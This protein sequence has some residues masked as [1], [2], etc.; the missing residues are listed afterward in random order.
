MLLVD[1]VGVELH[2][3]VA[4]L[5][6][7]RTV[8]E[9]GGNGLAGDEV[10]DFGGGFPIAGDAQ[11]F[12]RGGVAFVGG[13]N[14]GAV[15]RVVES[16]TGVGIGVDCLVGRERGDGEVGLCKAAVGVGEAASVGVDGV[17]EGTGVG[18]E[19]AEEFERHAE[20][21]P[22]GDDHVAFVLRVDGAR[23]D[24]VV[25]N[26]MADGD[27][28][29]GLEVV[30]V[31]GLVNIAQVVGRREDLD[32]GDVGI[33]L[34]T[35]SD[36]GA[37]DVVEGTAEVTTAHGIDVVLGSECGTG[38]A[39]FFIRGTA[40]GGQRLDDVLDEAPCGDVGLDD[41]E[42]VS[43]P[44]EVV[45]GE[46]GIVTAQE[47][48]ELGVE[49]GAFAVPPGVVLGFAF[50][51][52]PSTPLGVGAGRQFGA[53]FLGEELEVFHAV[54]DG[55][56]VAADAPV[57]AGELRVVFDVG[58]DH[59]LHQ[60]LEV[61]PCGGMENVAAPLVEAV[62]LGERT[63]RINGL[64]F[65]GQRAGTAPLEARDVLDA[66]LARGVEEAAV[67]R[68]CIGHGR[69]G[70][71]G[72]GGADAAPV[73]A[74]V[75]GDGFVTLLRLAVVGECPLDD[76]GRDGV[77]T[78]EFCIADKVLGVA[79]GTALPVQRQ[80]AL[81]QA[82]GFADDG[83]VALWI[84]LVEADA[85]D[86]GTAVPHGIVGVGL[87]LVHEVEPEAVLGVGAAGAAGAGGFVVEGDDGVEPFPLAAQGP[88]VVDVVLADA[89]LPADVHVVLSGLEFN[90]HKAG[91]VL[92]I[93][94][95][96]EI[97]GAR[98]ELA[99]A[100]A[101]GKPAIT[102]LAGITAKDVGDV[103]IRIDAGSEARVV[104]IE[105]TAHVGMRILGRI[106]RAVDLVDEAQAS[107]GSVVNA[108][109]Q[110]REGLGVA[111]GEAQAGECVTVAV[112]ELA[113]RGLRTDG[114]IDAA[115]EVD[116]LGDFGGNGEDGLAV[117]DRHHGVGH[118]GEPGG[119]G[120]AADG[121][122]VGGF[123]CGGRRVED[124]LERHAALGF[125]QVKEFGW[126]GFGGTGGAEAYAQGV[127]LNVERTFDEAAA[128]ADEGDIATPDAQGDGVLCAV[129]N[130]IGG[131]DVTAWD[132]V[133]VFVLTAPAADSDTVEPD[134]VI[135]RD[136][137]EVEQEG[138]A[139]LA[140]GNLDALAVPAPAVMVDA[141]RLPAFAG[142]ERLPC[143]VVVSRRKPLSLG[144][145]FACVGFELPFAGEADL[146]AEFA[147]DVFGEC[148]G[149]D[150]HVFDF[151]RGVGG[152][153]CG[154]AHAETGYV[155][156]VP[157][158]ECIDGQHDALPITLGG[159]EAGLVGAGGFAAHEQV[160][161]HLRVVIGADEEGDVFGFVARPHVA[162][163]AAVAGQE[164][165]DGGVRGLEQVGADFEYAIGDGEGGGVARGEFNRPTRGGSG[166]EEFGQAGV[167]FLLGG[168]CGGGEEQG[169]KGDAFE[170]EGTLIRV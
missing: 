62:G 161:A 28:I 39:F 24:L 55:H 40:T 132:D 168:E 129:F 49:R 67:L 165:A 141:L 117:F 11:D 65:F 158:F 155:V 156:E 8:F 60:L 87:E 94:D 3:A 72:L 38:G 170:H 118:E 130:E 63:E 107:V 95:A 59:V 73:I 92:R 131:H 30:E 148:D 115:C 9:F 110:R 66:E 143:A 81:G 45:E 6:D 86:G 83:E 79:V 134:F 75:D 46:V 41:A 14:V 105:P 108:F 147:Q 106:H 23:G 142:D 34:R 98:F 120:H 70:L 32:A 121:F 10:G 122:A 160:E 169:G 91:L 109:G 56:A 27:T 135:C 36:V 4:A 145:F 47:F 35:D 29:G 68:G 150:A 15:G 137:C 20:V 53:G 33:Q 146:R 43:V 85:R 5:Q 159:G 157:E 31:G 133:V 104:V 166:R 89:V 26:D 52:G 51:D 123:D 102:A 97:G 116:L 71:V 61:V 76:D 136:V 127:D 139:F 154:G 25:G 93:F 22:A 12:L 42:L 151:D 69:D 100:E 126:D 164:R 144:A 124:H 50:A 163:G 88:V 84:D 17:V 78:H 101:V 48:G 113:G 54:A 21:G 153:L 112:E 128:V 57:C 77:V 16:D 167:G 1:E 99:A 138:L 58:F 125:A 90:G 44:V 152:G 7:E 103:N 13:L 119:I 96:H 162:V 111:L 2:G 19:H 140:G 74:R 64:G 82:F 149:E 114:G 18:V 37:V 80:H